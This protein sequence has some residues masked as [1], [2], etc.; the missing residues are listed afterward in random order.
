MN[1][2]I[3]TALSVCLSFSV[4]PLSS[5]ENKTYNTTVTVDY[6]TQRYLND[7]SALDR[8]KYFNIHTSKDS[9]PDVRKFLADYGVGIGRSFWGPFSYSYGKTKRSTIYPFRRGRRTV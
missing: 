4:F 6:A 3:L 8:G 5:S 7:V 9:D 2:I 1:N